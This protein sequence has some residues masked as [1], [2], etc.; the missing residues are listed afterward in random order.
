MYFHGAW[1]DS[2][3][4]FYTKI[5]QQLG[6]IKMQSLMLLQTAT[7]FFFFWCICSRW[8][9][10]HLGCHQGKWGKPGTVFRSNT[11]NP[12]LSSN[13]NHVRPQVT[14]GPDHNKTRPQG[15]YISLGPGSTERNCPILNM[16]E[17]LLITRE[18]GLTGLTRQVANQHL[19]LA[20]C[21]MGRDRRH[22]RKSFPLVN[23][24]LKMT[25]LTCAIINHTTKA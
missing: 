20:A 17:C 25:R 24:N 16:L 14:K 21:E 9:G 5:L 8:W 3:V 6:L 11:T 7:W 15:S 22:R 2:F 19:R 1:F 12:F 13:C 18:N 10:W 4:A 23:F